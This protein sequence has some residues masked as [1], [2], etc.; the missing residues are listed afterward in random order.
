MNHVS[1]TFLRELQRAMR[2]KG[3]MKGEEKKLF[4]LVL[5]NCDQDQVGLH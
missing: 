1:H 4:C 3:R 5:D 2:C